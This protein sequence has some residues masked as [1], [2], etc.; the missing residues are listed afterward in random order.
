MKKLLTTVGAT[1]VLFA[2]ALPII[3]AIA[4]PASAASTT[5]ALS[6]QGTFSGIS[7]T[8]SSSIVFGVTAPATV[9][10]GSTM[11]VIITP[12]P[13]SIPGSASGLTVT[14]IT[15]DKISFT[16]PTGTSFVSASL[17]GGS[18]LGSGTPTVTGTGGKITLTVPGPL[19]GGSTVQLPTVT[20]VLKATGNAG[21]SV[22]TKMY[23]SS[24]G[25]PGQSFTVNVSGLGA[26]A[27]VCFPTPVATLST[28]S[29]TAPAPTAP[30]AP[31]IGTATAGQASATVTW[32]APASNG[33]AAITSYV[34]TPYIGATA[35]TA[36]LFDST[37]T[38]ETVTGLSNGSSY[39][40]KVAAANSVGTG[41]QSAASNA[42]M[43]TAPTV[44]GAPTIGTATAG[45]ARATVTWTAPA[46]TGGSAITGYSVTPFVG[47]T[48]GSAQV[49]NSTATS[50]SVTG[51]VNGT[52][53]TFKVA[54]ING[55]G[56]GPLSG[57]SNAVVPAVAGT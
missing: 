6:C 47:A 28:T 39:T 54:A 22:I 51:L 36:Q 13:T 41:A 37:A 25:D 16:I 7:Q 1:L 8:Q 12:G 21:S 43:P 15:N 29:V 19:A 5:Q 53:Y 14:S 4:P 46:A 45:I 11:S 30:G 48:A 27:T 55:V 3:A 35:Q 32:T 9:A 2:A 40:F 23:G 44:A 20:A 17:S 57:S 52:T 38:S 18:G 24:F 34:V 49:F 42:V 10:S 50:Q 31:T 56:T 33:G 26:V